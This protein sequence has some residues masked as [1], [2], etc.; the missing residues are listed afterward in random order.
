MA[1]GADQ[2]DNLWGFPAADPGS[3][4]SNCGSDFVDIAAPGVLVWTTCKRTDA[5]MKLLP[6]QGE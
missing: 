2:A 4:G 5:Q 6:P 3:S 1:L